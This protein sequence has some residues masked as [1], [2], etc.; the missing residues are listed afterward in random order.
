MKVSKVFLTILNSIFLASNLCQA[1][2][3]NEAQVLAEKGYELWKQGKII[4]ERYT[5]PIPEEQGYEF[6]HMGTLVSGK[7]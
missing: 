2:P 7:V 3:P 5:D 1:E 6:Q 4:N